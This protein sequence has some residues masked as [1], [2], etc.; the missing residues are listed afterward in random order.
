MRNF[1]CKQIPNRYLAYILEEMKI[2]LSQVLRNELANVQF[3]AKDIFGSCPIFE[4]AKDRSNMPQHFFADR[5]VILLDCSQ[6]RYHFFPF[7]FPLCASSPPFVTSIV[8]GRKERMCQE[9]GTA[10]EHTKS[11]ST[12]RRIH[13]C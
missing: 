10:I 8:K 5:T 6:V 7:T 12:N 11:T 3:V 13:Y 1:Q 4:F 2:L 9:V